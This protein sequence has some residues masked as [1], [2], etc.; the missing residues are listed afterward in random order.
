MFTR[1]LRS[2][3]ASVSTRLTSF[4]G[5]LMLSTM[6]RRESHGLEWGLHAITTS[7]V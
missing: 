4:S 5:S 7:P 1:V 3:S 2:R 6:L